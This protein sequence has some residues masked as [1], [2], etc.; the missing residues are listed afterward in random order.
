MIGD[1]IATGPPAGLA[2]GCA[3]AHPWGQ[4]KPANSAASTNEEE[5]GAEACERPEVAPR[6]V[7][8]SVSS[9]ASTS[10]HSTESDTL[11]VPVVSVAVRARA[12]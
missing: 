5:N 9:Q 2:A 8:R 4:T 7:P 11:R 6:G 10:F 1:S 12:T 3:G